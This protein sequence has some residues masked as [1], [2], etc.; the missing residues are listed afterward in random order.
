LAWSGAAKKGGAGAILEHPRRGVRGR[1][2]HTD[3]ARS[4]EFLRRNTR[5]I[6]DD[7]ERY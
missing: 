2:W 7:G 3:H 5:S 1:A 4:V 6:V